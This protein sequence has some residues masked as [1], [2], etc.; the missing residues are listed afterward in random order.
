MGIGLDIVDEIRIELGGIK[1]MLMQEL[2]K[3]K[4]RYMVP[5]DKTNKQ[6]IKETLIQIDD[7]DIEISV[8]NDIITYIKSG[9]NEYTNLDRI[10][11]VSNILEHIKTI[12]EH[13]ISRFGSEYTI[14]IEKIDSVN[15]S[16]AVI[17]SS[18]YE[19]ARA[20]VVRDGHGNIYINTLR[21][22]QET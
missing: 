11:D 7:L 12:K 14:S 21:S 5:Y 6:N 17:L 15:I 16:M 4:I 1:E 9:N 22:L 20:I 13:V 10:E 8:E 2:D 18:Q 19:R 3:H